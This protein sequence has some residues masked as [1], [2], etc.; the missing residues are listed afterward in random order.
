M[1]VM[2]HVCTALFSLG[3]AA[4]HAAGSGSTFLGG[5]ELRS[6]LLA[7]PVD[8]VSQ[9]GAKPVEWR[10]ASNGEANGDNLSMN[11][12]TSEYRGNWQMSGDQVC[13]KWIGTTPDGCVGLMSEGGTYE[14]Y[15]G[16]QDA[17][18]VVGVLR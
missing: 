11:T 13:V 17:P 5:D 4:A 1:R 14:L 3:I 16:S 15:T 7:S 2:L 10:F 12:D 8:F 18:I 9:P 6:R